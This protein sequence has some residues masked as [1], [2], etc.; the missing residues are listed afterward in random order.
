MS[1]LRAAILLTVL[2]AAATPSLGAPAGPARVVVVLGQSGPQ[3]HDAAKGIATYLAETRLEAT[4]EHVPAAVLPRAAAA[5]SPPA[6]YVAIG[7]EA[8]EAVETV[9][10]GV[11]VVACLILDESAFSGKKNVT[12]V[13]LRFPIETELEWIRK[14]LP[15]A[16]R[17]G[18]LYHSQENERR[19]AAAKAAAQTFGLTIEARRVADPAEIPPALE[20]LGKSSDVLWGLADATVLTPATAKPI[21]LFSLRNRIPF[22]GLSLPWVRAGALYAID[23]DY[24]DVGRQCGEMLAKVLGG[25]PV[26]SIPPEPPRAAVLMLNRKTAERLKVELSPA[27]LEKATEVVE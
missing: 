5:S 20:A 1:V 12:G 10:P 21:L 18:V 17:I 26:A 16:R 27:L 4:I 13:H 6:L 2:T 25:R 14:F 8:L 19:I 11:P 22:V 23:R 7:R 24:P 15:H 9:A 3:Y